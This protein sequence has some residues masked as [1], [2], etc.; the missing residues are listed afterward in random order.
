MRLRRGGVLALAAALAAALGPLAAAA[1]HERRPVDCAAPAELL[2]LGEPL[3][4][5][6]RAVRHDRRLRIVAVGSS[7]TSGVGASDAA[8]AYPARLAIELAPRFAGVEIEVLN[9]GIGGETADQMLAR[10]ERD[11]VALKPHLVL[12]QVGSNSVLKGGG[13]E[14]LAAAVRAGVGRIRAA[15]ADVVLIDLQY[16]PRI[17]SRPMHAEVLRALRSVVSELHVALFGRF[18]VMRHWVGSGRLGFD[19]ALSADQLHLSDVSY[20]CLAGALATSLEAA[21]AETGPAVSAVSP[22]PRR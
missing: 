22:A 8:H 9:K 11:V 18:A 14:A 3:P 10:F 21:V 12:W 5:T 19:V 13:V 7:S 2:R 1:H 16:A 6:A 4:E 20:A 17:L 15:K